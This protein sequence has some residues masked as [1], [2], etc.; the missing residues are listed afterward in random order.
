[1]LELDETGKTLCVWY[2]PVKDDGERV[3]PSDLVV[4][5]KSHQFR[6]PHCLC[7]LLDEHDPGNHHEVA[8]VMV[9]QGPNAGEYLACCASSK[10]GYFAFI[11]KLHVSIGLPVK[12]Y[13]RRR[14]DEARPLDIVFV[15]GNGTY[16]SKLGRVDVIERRQP[17]GNDTHTMFERLM[18][19]DSFTRPG[20]TQDEFRRFLT[21]CNCCKLIMM[22][23]MFE[24]HDCVGQEKEGDVEIIDLTTSDAY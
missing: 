14:P 20:L 13:P 19:L 8:I 1:M 17:R 23:H 11:E 10:C 6:G 18:K 2:W 15:D 9:T 4:Y 7:L 12:C 5:R 22:R 3:V 16:T 21:R 24:R